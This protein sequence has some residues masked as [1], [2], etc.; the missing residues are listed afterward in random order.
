MTAKILI[1]YIL[2][3]EIFTRECSEGK[4]REFKQFFHR[5][6]RAKVTKHSTNLKVQFFLGIHPM[7][8]GWR[9][10]RYF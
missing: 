5:Y 2:L 6:S 3:I 1:C 8:L 7:P 4:A 9:V 10:I